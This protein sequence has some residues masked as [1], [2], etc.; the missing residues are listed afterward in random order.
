MIKQIVRYSTLAVL[1]MLL[2]ATTSRTF[3]HH[4]S[5]ATTVSQAANNGPGGGDPEP[6]DPG[7]GVVALHLS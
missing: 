7:P 1:V 5:L 4:N 2:G 6:T 3:T